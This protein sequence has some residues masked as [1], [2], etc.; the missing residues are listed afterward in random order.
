MKRVTL[1]MAALCVAG[2][3]AATDLDVKIAY[4]SK[5]VT[6][7]GVVREARYEEKMLRRAGHVWSSRVL[8]AHVEEHSNGAPHK[9]FNHVVLPRHVILENGKPR[10]EFVDAHAKEV[11]RVPPAEYDNVSFDGSWDHAYYLLDSKRLKAMPVTARVSSVAGA[12]WRE[13]EDKGLFERVLWD[14]QRQ[15]PLVIESGDKAATFFN[16]MELTV[17]PTLTRDLPWQKLKGYSQ[18]E[19]S[20]FLD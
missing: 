20:D 19:Y 9:H 2:S 18:K 1:L 6:A 11:V 14:D 15:V 17:Q 10:V 7:E 12:R 4:Y 13:R 5:V 16:R 3:A 8:P